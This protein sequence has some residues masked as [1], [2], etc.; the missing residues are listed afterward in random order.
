MVDEWGPWTDC[1][2]GAAQGLADGASALVASG[3]GLLGYGLTLR[4][5]QRVFRRAKVIA[6]VPSFGF[7]RSGLSLRLGGRF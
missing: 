5:R 4:K 6:T 2:H 3:G 1:R 7:G